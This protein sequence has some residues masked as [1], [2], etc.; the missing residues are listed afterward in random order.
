MRV[1]SV[2]LGDSDSSIAF[3][4]WPLFPVGN[5]DVVSSAEQPQSMTI[6]R[7]HLPFG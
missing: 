6:P 3:G 1:N 2:T 5:I 4:V 7:Y